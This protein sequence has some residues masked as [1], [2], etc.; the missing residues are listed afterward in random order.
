MENSIQRL[1][2]LSREVLAII[3]EISRSKQP[4]TADTL[5]ILFKQ[6]FPI[7]DILQS[8]SS[9]LTDFDDLNRK[10]NQQLSDIQKDYAFLERQVLELRQLSDTKDRNLR[11]LACTLLSLD[12]LK[13]YSWYL[14]LEETMKSCEGGSDLSISYIESLIPQIKNEVFKH[15]MGGDEEQKPAKHGL[16]SRLFAKE[17]KEFEIG[18]ISEIV[19]Q[20]FQHLTSEIN[21]PGYDRIN[22]KSQKFLDDFLKN[23]RLDKLD[24][25]LETLVDL[26]Q[27]LKYEYQNRRAEIDN[28]LHELISRLLETEQEFVEHFQKTSEQRNE[29]QQMF[30]ADLRQRIDSIGQT[31]QLFKENDS[32]EGL[33]GNVFSALDGLRNRIEEQR[34]DEQNQILEWQQQI[35]N[36]KEKLRVAQRE[37]ESIK[38]TTRMMEKEIMLDGLTGIY[39]RRAFDHKMDETVKLF[40]RHLVPHSLIMFDIDHFKMINDKYG[41]R[42]GDN[43]IIRI[44]KNIRDILRETDF[45]ARYGGEEFA[46]LLYDCTLESALMV[47]EKIRKIIEDI[48][49][50][51][52]RNEILRITISLGVAELNNQ[53]DVESFINRSDQALYLAKNQGRN[54]VRSQLDHP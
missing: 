20:K 50:T 9:N 5:K 35:E 48:T 31:F 15:H 43:A 2:I 8:K 29:S 25:Y 41:H 49:F 12:P 14:N 13:Q 38:E 27:E 42:V 1:D 37:L 17:Q 21:L 26:L 7:M 33:R 18:R 34:R 11:N 45:F 6:N 51:Y 32:F 39:N 52:K 16:L 46:V 28:F 19:Y 36:L 53:D 3:K 4:V 47:A 24:Q 54:L 10:L 44:I 30:Q 22:R 23:F 40:R